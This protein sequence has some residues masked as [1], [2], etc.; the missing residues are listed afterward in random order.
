MKAIQIVAFDLDG[1]LLDSDKNISE[2]NIRA[3]ARCAEKGIYVV[4]TTGRPTDG[5]PKRIRELPGVRYAITTNGGAIVDLE[6]GEQLMSC[7]LSPEKAVELLEITRE[8]D[9]MADPYIGGRAVTEERCMA[10]LHHYGLSEAMQTMVHDTRDVVSDVVEYVSQVGKGVEK[11]NIFFADIADRAPLRCRLERESGIAI[12]TAMVN[13]L[14]LNDENA[15]KGNG[16][17]WLADYLGVDREATM[18]IGDGENDVSMIRMAGVGVAM[19]NALDLVKQYADEITLTNDE[20]G[21]AAVIE[22]LIG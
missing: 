13:N 16:L 6:T 7:T 2:R 4:P 9:V 1:T 8:F 5:V 14:E 21:V 10:R 3:L 11:I 12:T 15:T 22:R 20:D 19:D 18:A 17:M